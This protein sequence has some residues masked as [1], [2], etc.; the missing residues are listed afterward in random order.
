[1]ATV[2]PFLYVIACSIAPERNSEQTFFIIPSKFRLIPM[3]IFFHPNVA[4]GVSDFFV[5]TVSGSLTKMFFTLTMAYP[6]QR[7]PYRKELPGN[8]YLYGLWRRNA[9]GFLVIKALVHQ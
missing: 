9:P 5:V 2:L 6:C 8:G 4:E 7:K 1:M 3:S